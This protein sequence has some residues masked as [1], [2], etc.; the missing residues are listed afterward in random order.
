[1]RRIALLVVSALVLSAPALAHDLDIAQAR[2]INFPKLQDGRS[3][4]AVDLHTHSVFSDGMVWPDVRVEEAKRDGLFAMAVSEH[5]EYQPKAADIPH[6]DRNRSFQ[7]ASEAAKIRPDAIGPNKQPLMVLNGSEI[8]KLVIQPGHMNAV[9]IT[10]A[11][12]LMPK[13]GLNPVDA[14]REQLKEANAQ[15]GFTFWNHPYWTSQTPNGIATLDPVHAEFIKSGLLHGIEVANGADMSDEAFKIALDNNITILGTSDVH[16][17]IDWEY[18]LEHGGHRTATLVLTNSETPDGLKAALKAG[19]TVAIYNDNL[20][21]KPANVE[22]VVRSTLKIEV[23]AALPRT[24]VVPVSVI[25]DSPVDYV[26]EN[27][28]PEGAY[29][30]GHVFTV[31][32]GST[33]TLLIKN[34][35]DASRLSLTFKA[36]NTY[37]APRE[38]LTVQLRDTTP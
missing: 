18:D 15:G 17:L 19:N 9:F 14:A 8:T 34:V 33:F 25:N 3:V 20:V 28:G 24:T 30:E 12:K 5:L 23:D 36:L 10:D 32:S 27:M 29:D 13:A 16:G 6:K 2:R 21:G 7:V 31:K 11:N 38:H 1:M 26:L 37:I 4:L 22:A 35:P